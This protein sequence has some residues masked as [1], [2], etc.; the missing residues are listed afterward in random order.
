MSKCI[1]PGE[2]REYLRAFSAKPVIDKTSWHLRLLSSPNSPIVLVQHTTVALGLRRTARNNRVKPW[3]KFIV[4]PGP[5]RLCNQIHSLSTIVTSQHEC[6][7]AARAAPAYI[8][9]PQRKP[10][11]T[12]RLL[13][14]L[15]IMV[16]GVNSLSL[17]GSSHHRQELRRL[18][19]SYLSL[20]QCPRA[21][22]WTCRHG[23]EFGHEQFGSQWK[24]ESNS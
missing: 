19:S 16:L 5:T 18:R 8:F 17:R 14:D 10:E 9:L 2:A 12:P 22:E 4:V 20:S 23:E 1:E 11:S 21:A 13:L 15:I 7:T 6:P 3:Y 24:Q